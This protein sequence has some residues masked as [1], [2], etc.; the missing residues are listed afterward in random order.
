MFQMDDISIIQSLEGFEWKGLG[1]LSMSS[2]AVNTNFGPIPKKVI[3]LKPAAPITSVAMDTSSGL[4]VQFFKYF[5][6]S[7][8][9]SKK[10]KFIILLNINKCA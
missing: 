2:S 9:Q 10:K 1:P 4:Y 3:Q 7:I 5:K 6:C 8:L